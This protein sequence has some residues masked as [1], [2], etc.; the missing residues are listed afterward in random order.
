M[1]ILILMFQFIVYIVIQ[2]SIS[3]YLSMDDLAV[4]LT[5]W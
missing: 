3:K 5:L 4:I 2:H 1:F